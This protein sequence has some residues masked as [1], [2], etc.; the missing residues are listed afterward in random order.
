VS[1]GESGLPIVILGGG[2]AG[3]AAGIRL[4]RKGQRVVLFERDDHVGGLAGGVHIGG[5]TY[6]YG[7][8]IFHTTDPE[9]LE[10]VKALVGPDLLPYERTIRIRFLGNYFQFPLAVR[11][12]LFK[13][14]VPTV[15]H[16]GLSFLWHFSKGLF[17]SPPE[18]NS[19]TLLTRYYGRVLYE[20]FFKSYI[21]RVWGIPPSQFSPSFARERIPR[22]NL[23][24]LL[25]KLWTM[26]R[27]RVGHDLRTEG[28]VEKVEGNLYTTRRGFSLITERMADGLRARG[29]EVR[30][31]ACVTRIHREGNGFP[32]VEVA[33]STGTHRVECRGILNTL[34]LNEVVRMMTPA[35]EGEV[36]AA[37][38]GLRFRALVFVGVVVRRPR[39]LPASFVYFR[40]HSFNRISDL[41][42]FGF[43]IHPPGCTI[44]VAEIACSTADDYWKD[45]ELAQRAVLQD[46]EREEL[47]RGDEVV[48]T[49]VF[50][51]AHAYPVYTLHYEKHR[52]TLLDA[53]ER[54]S[55]META[56][57]QGR[58]AYINTHVAMKMG[59]E[60][61]DRLVAK[62]G[63]R[64]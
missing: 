21:T 32:A 47:A 29:A 40:E 39:V 44:L 56:G 35:P 57:R 63:G 17:V 41:S 18:E 42:Q 8:H 62:L 7:P 9:I 33:D 55:N 34:P 48:E 59:Y 51:S 58:F 23:L 45:E 60:A 27:R 25:D 53:I 12:V 54:T 28:Y 13:L 10:D 36:S 2:C 11:D 19:E 46:L 50:R 31:N 22:L 24:S 16:A 52:K 3:L 5:N 64:P 20:I 49:H 61:A 43:E 6:E 4:T 14:P 26:I 30:L 1:S 15:I 37:A 38:E